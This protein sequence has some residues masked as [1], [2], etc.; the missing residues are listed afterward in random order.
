MGEEAKAMALRSL[1]RGGRKGKGETR[2][3]GRLVPPSSPL[4][5]RLY[6]LCLR[7][8]NTERRDYSGT[9]HLRCQVDLLSIRINDVYV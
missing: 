6:N 1:R 5:N 9:L 4:G 2:G 3:L 8:A 7:M